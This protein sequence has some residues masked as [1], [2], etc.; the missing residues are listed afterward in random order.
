MTHILP[1]GQPAD[2][3]EDYVDAWHEFAKPLQ[4]V[5]GASL[6]SYDPNLSLYFQGRIVYFDHDVVEMLNRALERKQ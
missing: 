4:D 2:T 1:N 5:L 6:M 3:V